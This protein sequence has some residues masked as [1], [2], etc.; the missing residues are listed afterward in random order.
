MLSGNGDVAACQGSIVGCDHDQVGD[1]GCK[2]TF[3]FVV[4][5]VLGQAAAA[6]PAAPMDISSRQPPRP[7][8]CRAFPLL[9]RLLSLGLVSGLVRPG[10][11]GA[12]CV[13]V[14]RQ[15]K[16]GRCLHKQPIKPARIAQW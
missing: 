3:S 5:V 11:R 7:F 15:A 13:S 14:F 1:A 6:A 16:G 9:A 12:L 8:F 2:R 10:W 4:V